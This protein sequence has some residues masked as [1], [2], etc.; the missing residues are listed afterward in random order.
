[1]RKVIF[2][3]FNIFIWMFNIINAQT[4]NGNFQIIQNNNSEIVVNV[5]LNLNQSTAALGNAVIRFNFNDAALAFPK[6]PIENTDFFI[7]NLDSSNY[8]SS[9]S[10]SS[11]GV[12]SINIAQ[13]GANYLNLS[14]NYIDFATLYFKLNNPND[15]LNIKPE[16]LQFFSPASSDE[17]S[18]GTWNVNY[19]V[20]GIKENKP[21]QFE[22]SQNYPNPFNP[23]TMIN[24]SIPISS[25]V[26]IKLY[27]ALGEEISTLVRDF[28]APGKYQYQLNAGNLS[29]GIY[30][31]KI[32]AGPFT[33]TKKMLL[34]K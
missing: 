3:L 15:S 1:M 34:L 25:Y 5:Q 14:T 20:T 4:V 12:A 32:Q 33:E 8:Y 6:N 9:V 26:I 29:S 23:S 28:K 27:N 31:Y 11:P 10:L 17:W 21:N 30:F 16:L 13:V 7:H 19:T 24:Y 2:L 22:L 18:I